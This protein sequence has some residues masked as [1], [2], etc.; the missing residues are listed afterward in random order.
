MR[1]TNTNLRIGWLRG[2]ACSS[3]MP[4]SRSNISSGSPIQL[5]TILSWLRRLLS[6][7]PTPRLTRSLAV[8]KKRTTL[9]SGLTKCWLWQGQLMGLRVLRPS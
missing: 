6:I 3:A 5:S 4:A 1:S 2:G 9:G 7:S 8:A